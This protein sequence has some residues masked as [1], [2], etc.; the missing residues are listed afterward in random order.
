MNGNSYFLL[1]CVHFKLVLKK[2]YTRVYTHLS[3]IRHSELE[4]TYIVGSVRLFHI[5]RNQSLIVLDL[6][7]RCSRPLF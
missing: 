6:Y 4:S 1:V 2:K 7:S 3:Y 5:L